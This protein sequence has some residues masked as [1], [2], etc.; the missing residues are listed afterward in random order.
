MK[1]IGVYT[2]NKMTKTKANG[3]LKN[4]S[5]LQLGRKNSKQSVY[6]VIRIIDGVA[7]FLEEHFSRLRQSMQIEGILFE[8]EFQ[9]FNRNTAE[10]IEIDQTLNGNIKFIYSVFESE[11]KWTFSFIPHSYPSQE[12]YLKG[13]RTDLFFAERENPNAK[14]IQDI[15]RNRA[16]QMIEDHELY[17]VLLVDRDGLITEGSRSNV[18]FV[19]DDVFYTAPASMVLVGVTRQKVLECLTGLG[20]PVI[21]EAVGASEI[22]CYDAVFLTGTSPGILPVRS[23]GSQVFNTQH[24]LVKRL[25]NRYNDLIT[26]Y[27]KN[28]KNFRK[29]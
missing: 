11:N 21:E 1:K 14:V 2:I 24:P 12:D 9:E 5:E 29:E 6:E 23:I 28:E 16:N 4:D 27:I 25:I 26:Q 3:D 7:L 18:F 19:K 20:L 17:E 15:I 8:M 10:L 13:V 22:G